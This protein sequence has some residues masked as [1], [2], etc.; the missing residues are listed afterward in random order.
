LSN[1]LL[2][3]LPKFSKFSPAAPEK[4]RNPA[5]WPSKNP[6]IFA[7]G[8]EKVRGDL[9]WTLSV[10]GKFQGAKVNIKGFGLIT[11]K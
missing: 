2:H 5:L 4:G 1:L 3:F 8:A 7:C 11:R 6:K 9:R 10:V